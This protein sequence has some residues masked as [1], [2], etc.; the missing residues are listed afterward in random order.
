MKKIQ[1]KGNCSMGIETHL[2]NSIVFCVMKDGAMT[3]TRETP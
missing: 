3:L 1:I 2:S